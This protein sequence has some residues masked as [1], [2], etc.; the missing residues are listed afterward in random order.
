MKI[1]T[2]NVNS[3]NVRLAQVLDWITANQID[4]L[5]MQET[6]VIDELFPVDAFKLMG[7]HICFSGQKTYNGVAIISR[8]QLLELCKYNPFFQDEA[9]RVIAATID[10]IRVINLYI[11]NGQSVGSEKYLYKL[12]WLKAIHQFLKEELAKYSKV[13]VM[14]DFNIAPADIDVYEPLVWEGNVMV[15][16]QEREAFQSMLALGFVDTLRHAHPEP[17]LYTWWDYRQ[18]AFRRNRGLRIDHILVSQSLLTGCG[19]VTIDKIARQ[20]ERPSDHAPV[21]I[22][23]TL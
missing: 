3:I 15:S 22:N 10:G 17:G 12:A 6:K 11:P 7:Y 1:A 16:Q 20:S 13:I 8:S 18:G 5:A 4:V 19:A 21:W 23:L 14:G 2:W 9:Q